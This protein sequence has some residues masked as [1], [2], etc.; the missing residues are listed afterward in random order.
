MTHLLWRSRKKERSNQTTVN[1][2]CLSFSKQQPTFHCSIWIYIYFI[3]LYIIISITQVRMNK[4]FPYIGHWTR[5]FDFACNLLTLGS[6][7]MILMLRQLTK[8]RVVLNCNSH[9]HIHCQCPTHRCTFCCQFTIDSIL[10][11]API[12]LCVLNNEISVAT[13]FWFKKNL[14]FFCYAVL[15]VWFVAWCAS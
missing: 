12:M 5:V 1:Q 11:R 4:A 10:L 3:Q 6:S 15:F 14:F 8:L 9:A 13:S 7:R 2:T